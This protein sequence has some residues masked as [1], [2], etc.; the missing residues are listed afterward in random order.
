[1]A[2]THRIFDSI[3]QVPHD[4]WRRICGRSARHFFLQ[5]EFIGV[6]EASMKATTRFWH[7]MLYDADREPVAYATL[8]LLTIDLAE[9][10]ARQA[11]TLIRALPQSV[12][13]FRWFKML[14]CG[15]PVSLGQ[16]SLAYTAECN[17]RGVLQAIDTVVVQISRE[18]S[19]DVIVYKE[20]DQQELEPTD[21]LV[22]RG[23]RRFDT[24]P[25]NYFECTFGS[26]EAYCAAL[27]SHYRKK[28]KLSMR[29]LERAGGR[30]RI[31]TEP[32]EILAT[33]SSDVHR[34]YLAVVHKA[35][36]KLEILPLE[37][38]QELVKR[39][40]D[41]VELAL[42]ER[43]SNIL[44]FGWTLRTE[45]SY[46]PLFLG[47]DYR[48]NRELDLYFNLM[49]AVLDAGMRTGL[50]HI[51]VG[52]TADAFKAK[53]GC[54]TQPRYVFARGVGW[55][56]GGLFRYGGRLFARIDPAPIFDIFRAPSPRGASPAPVRR[57]TLT[58]Y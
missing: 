52:Q 4:D 19:A 14:L 39:F 35:S 45:C 53:L 55:F 43:D 21:V 23:Y 49:Y 25:M 17:S 3:E 10:T 28:I 44:A 12:S 57:Q 30:I 8:S 33:Y 41:R 51:H 11:S 26:F 20:F 9:L 13:R 38:F 31:L 36:L 40:P 24:P 1:M 6:V 46:H 27:K 50:P 22:S 58:G 37:F 32:L 42:V 47:I 18:A 29:K 15:V 56:M 16:K 54:R 7:V 2:Y 34:L 48:L 5:P